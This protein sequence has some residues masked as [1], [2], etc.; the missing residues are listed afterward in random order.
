MDD[1]ERLKVLEEALAQML[2]SVKGIPFSVIVKSLAE[3]EVIQ[4]NKT[5]AADVELLNRLEKTIQFCAAELKSNPIKRPRPNE[6]GNDV[7][8]YVMRAL[9]LAGL[10][11]GRPRSQAG[12]GKSSLALAY[13]SFRYPISSA[14]F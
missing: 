1:K 14:T 13:C 2:K 10:K 9:P 8:A 3:R 7:E 12:L 4:I 11:A 5:D 6:V